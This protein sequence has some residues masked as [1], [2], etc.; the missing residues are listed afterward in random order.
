MHVSTNHK[1]NIKFQLNSSQ[2]L[3][4]S[5]RYTKLN[6]CPPPL[7]IK[8]ELFL[9]HLFFSPTLNS[10]F[11]EL[12]HNGAVVKNLEQ[13]DTNKRSILQSNYN[14]IFQEVV[15]Y[16]VSSIP[17]SSR[18]NS[19]RKKLKRIPLRFQE[20]I[21]VTTPNPI[22]KFAHFNEPLEANDITPFD[23]QEVREVKRYSLEELE[24][25]YPKIFKEENDLDSHFN[26]VFEVRKMETK[27]TPSETVSRVNPVYLNKRE[28]EILANNDLLKEVNLSKEDA[29][30]KKSKKLKKLRKQ[31][32]IRNLGE[33]DD[34]GD[35]T[36]II[37][38]LTHN[39]QIKLLNGKS[40][41]LGLGPSPPAPPPP[42]Q[43][44]NKKI[45]K[46]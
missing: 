30:P 19:K 22:N 39:P 13:K 27:F 18:I 46:N 29:K 21:E 7:Y 33:S 42:D 36:E 4:L 11:D 14:L 1:N 9:R 37:I 17:S 44:K 10:L 20:V 15:P 40:G 6:T 41:I 3:S 24:K 31:N 12:P 43:C 45:N 32:R 25:Q 2:L 38:N 35:R 23:F 16:N 5:F 28:R 26:E 34:S 8:F